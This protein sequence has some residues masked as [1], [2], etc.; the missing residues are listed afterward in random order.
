MKFSI[1][2]FF[3]KPLAQVNQQKNLSR[4]KLLIFKYYQIDPK[5]IK[6]PF[7]WWG[8]DEAMFP[9][10]CFLAYQILGIVGSQIEIERFFSLTCIFTNLKKCRL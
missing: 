1:W 7:Q 2:I 4:K 8:K 10:V 9:I 3:N 5:E 6:S